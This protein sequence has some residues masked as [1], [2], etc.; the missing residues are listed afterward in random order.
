MA[1]VTIT[2]SGNVTR[3]RSPINELFIIQA[4]KLGGKWTHEGG[5]WEFDARDEQRVRDLSV[6]YYGSDG[7][8][9]D[10]C[11]LRVAFASLAYA[12]RGPYTI[13]GRPIARA[14]GRDSGAKQG[15]GIVFLEGGCKSGGSVKNW[16]TRIN[17]GSVVLVRDFPRAKAEKLAASEDNSDPHYSI[18]PETAPVDIPALREERSKLID[19]ISEIDKVL[20]AHAVGIAETQD[21]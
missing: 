5:V 6:R 9:D 15:D 11:T 7:V 16:D 12:D 21:A 20:T 19:R 2:T 17:S 3:V 1:I 18:E 4:K 13:Y 14:W 10:V 8:T